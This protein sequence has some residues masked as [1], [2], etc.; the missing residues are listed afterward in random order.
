ML[1]TLISTSLTP[2]L[3]NIFIRTC[4]WGFMGAAL[5]LVVVQLIDSTLKIVIA[6]WHNKR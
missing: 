1:V 4:D 2:L 3:N 6:I 5:T